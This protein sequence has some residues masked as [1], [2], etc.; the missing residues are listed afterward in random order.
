MIHGLRHVHV[1]VD[2]AP[3]A[4][5]RSRRARRVSDL[6]HRWLAPIRSREH[7]GRG[8]LH[9]RY[10][11]VQKTSSSCGNTTCEHSA[12][13]LV[14]IGPPFVLR[15]GKC[16]PCR[17]VGCG[18]VGVAGTVTS[19][20]R[21]LRWYRRYETKRS[22]ARRVKD[23]RWAIADWRLEEARQPCRVLPSQI[24]NQPSPIRW[25]GGST[26]PVVRA[27]PR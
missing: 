17:R 26:R 8:C 13:F 2:M 9:P 4:S 22:A 18:R 24:A 1:D 7:Q 6:I 14:E 5:R 16:D 10:G 21:P 3:R 19:S 12:N 15:C 27:S 11:T 23:L 25:P 20:L